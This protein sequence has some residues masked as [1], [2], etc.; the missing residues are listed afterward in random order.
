MPSPNTIAICGKGRI[1]SAAL[2]YL[3]H[4]LAANRLD[5]PVVACPNGDD[6]GF[7]TW[8]QSLARSAHLLGVRRAET[9]ELETD[10][11]LLLISLEY[12]KIIPVRRFASS[13]LFN[14]HFSE[15]PKYR[16]VLTSV[17]PIL[18]GETH[19]GVTLHQMD[20]GVDTGAIVAQRRFQLPA[21]CTARRLY[22][23]YMDEA[24]VL[25]REQI[26][27]LVSGSYTTTPQDASRGSYYDRKSLDL[28]KTEIDLTQPGDVICRFVRAMTFPEYQLPTLGGRA[29]RSCAVVGSQAQPSPRQPTGRPLRETAYSTSYLAGDDTVVELVWG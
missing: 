9:K 2:S 5:V 3:V 17:W 26:G 6:K 18:N 27:A 21:D 1:A 4:W 20:P 11:S 10:A 28:R 15:L 19:A 23:L 29:V 8:Q 7:D 16:G 24:L 14:I 22:D 12:D 25:F 13:T